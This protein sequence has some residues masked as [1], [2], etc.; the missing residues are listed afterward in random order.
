MRHR[1]NVSKACR[2]FRALAALT[3][4]LCVTAPRTRAQ[5]LEKTT[6]DLRATLFA[7]PAVPE[8]LLPRPDFH[9]EW[10]PPQR[11]RP[12]RMSIAQRR[13]WILLGAAQH[14]A[15]FF[16]ARTTRDAMRHYR[17]LD[18]LLRPFAHSEALYPAMQLGPVGLDWLA[19]R[20][21]TSPHRW[22]RRLWWVPQA[23]ATAGFLWSGMHNLR[24]PATS[25]VPSH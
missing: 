12:P 23:A 11:T 13:A 15:A 21:A 16:D 25:G 18:P 7:A 22:L 3:F 9:P 2:A 4:I 14:G 17:E 24:L 6:P 8:R 20:L 10:I 19:T 1:K 5:V